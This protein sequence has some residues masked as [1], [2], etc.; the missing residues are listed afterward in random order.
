MDP[1]AE[2]LSLK[3]G[4]KGG[5]SGSE[6]EFEDSKCLIEDRP[7]VG[8][9]DHRGWFPAWEER[10]AWWLPQ[11]VQGYNENVGTR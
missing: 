3:L 11:L 9:W 7:C 4:R 1:G 6:L 10:Q 8:C 2:D 5:R